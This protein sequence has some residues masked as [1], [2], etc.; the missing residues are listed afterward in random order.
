MNKSPVFVETTAVVDSALKGH[1]EYIISYLKKQG[2]GLSTNYVRMEI[3][4]GPLQYMTALHNICVNMKMFSLVVKKISNLSASLQ[5]YRLSMYLECLSQF[6]SNI[7]QKSTSVLDGDEIDIII[8]KMIASYLRIQIKVIWQEIEELAK[9]ITN[10]MRCFID[11]SPPKIK[12]GNLLDNFPSKCNGGKVECGIR[13]FFKDNEDDFK[14]I[15]A[16]LDMIPIGERDTETLKRI[17]A[18]KNIIRLL[19]YNRKFSNKEPNYRLCWNCGDAIIAVSSP[20]DS[21]ILTSNRKH[22]EP[23]CESINRILFSYKI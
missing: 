4:R 3:K 10:P 15:L 23:I 1:R 9:E 22:Y 13:E 16:R 6:F 11:I 19:P 14:K 20:S 12:E 2:I 7:G 18:L 8:A 21:I 5:K 17:G